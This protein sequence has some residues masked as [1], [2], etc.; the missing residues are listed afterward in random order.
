[1]THA[2]EG[3][4]CPF[5]GY[6]AGV[7]NEYGGGPEHVVERTATT[8]SFVS[9]RWWPRNPGHVIVVPTAHYENLYDVPY[10]VGGDLFAAARRAALAL[11]AAYG[12]PGTSTR[13]HNEPAGDQEVWHFHWHVFPRWPG[14]RLYEE[15]GFGW[16]DQ[17]EMAE[18]AERLRA[19][20][21]GL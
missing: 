11:K 18:R 1:M 21:A 3:Y 7:R 5:C 13:Q 17:G 14:D 16:A 8:L 4:D 9:P 6:A 20:Y 10:D 2:P 12:C 19:A 15:T